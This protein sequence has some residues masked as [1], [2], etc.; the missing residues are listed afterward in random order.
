MPHRE[1]DEIDLEHII[2]GKR[3]IKLDPKWKPILKY[4]IAFLCLSI[5]F[6]VILNFRGI[7]SNITYWYQNQFGKQTPISYQTTVIKADPKSTALVSLP[8]IE[9][10]TIYIPAINVTAPVSWHIPNED[11]A[12][13]AGL[14]QGVIQLEGTALPGTVGNVFITGHSSNFVWAKGAYNQI[15]A[16]LHNLVNGDKVY[17]RYNGVTYQYQ[18][19][20][21]EIVKPDNLSVLNQTQQ[22]ILTLMTCTPVGTNYRRLIITAL[23]TY[24][25]PSKNTDFSGGVNTS[26]LPK[27]R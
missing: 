6:Y 3:R 25:D 12:L 11:A 27:A 16:L 20:G 17:L 15:F 18:V 14:E 21:S 4:V 7:S 1:I 13:T 8:T 24:P 5:I 26:T 9:N 10:N 23:Q 19:S 22:S 2:S